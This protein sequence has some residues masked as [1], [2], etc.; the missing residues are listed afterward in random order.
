MR[1]RAGQPGAFLRFSLAA[2]MLVTAAATPAAGIPAD[3][4]PG[5][6]SGRVT[7]ETTGAPIAG[8]TIEF[9]RSDHDETDFVGV[10][11]AAGNYIASGWTVGT[12]HARTNNG[13]GY[14]DEL[15]G[16]LPCAFPSA[17]PVWTC[18][19]AASTSIVL[20][21]AP[22]TSIDFVLGRGGRITGMVTDA[23][24]RA[25]LAGV[26]VG[27]DLVRD[28]PPAFGLAQ[29]TTDPAGA[30]LLTGLPSGSFVASTSNDQGYVNEIY[31]GCR[32]HRECQGAPIAVTAGATTSGIDFAL[33]E[34]G[35]V[36]GRVSNAAGESLVGVG[37]GLRRSGGEAAG[38]SNSDASGAW[39][40]DGL[41][42][43]TYF[44]VSQNNDEVIKQ[45]YIDEIFNDL[46]WRPGRD[47]AEGQPIVVRGGAAT[48]GVDFVLEPG[49]EIR[50]VVT[51]AGT[52]A[53]IEARIWIQGDSSGRWTSRT[54]GSGSYVIRGLPSGAYQVRVGTAGYVEELFEDVPCPSVQQQCPG[55]TAVSVSPGS[56][57]TVD[58]A[59]S[60]GGEIAG[61]VTQA[62]SGSPINLHS[63]RIIATDGQPVRET[64]TGPDGSYS[65]K[66]LA[67]GTYYVRTGREEG[68]WY[69]LRP[70]LFLEELFDDQPCLGSC[71]ITNGTPVTVTAGTRATGVDFVLST[72]GRIKGQV[73]DATTGSRL[74]G[75][76]VEVFDVNGNPVASPSSLVP[77]GYSTRPLP[78]G[79]YFARTVGAGPYEDWL[80]GS[81]PCPDGNCTVTDG[82]PITVTAGSAT[83]VDFA[84]RRPTALHTIAPC[85]VLDTRDPDLGGPDPLAA[86]SRRTL[87]MA[88]AACGIPDSAR[89]VAANVTVVQPAATGHL[90][91]FRPD[92]GTPAASTANYSAG[93]ARATNAVIEVSYGQF[94]A[95]VGQPSGTVHVIIDATGYFE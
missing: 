89:A 34:G 71:P 63:V 86:G 32:H 8:V 6:I 46:V 80:Y 19:W 84:L 20:T 64:V 77:D 48:T 18:D 36:A 94:T 73:T 5:P 25:P 2:C 85:R 57:V 27:I 61:V 82:T 39:E 92:A 4:V 87:A 83:Q 68:T 13:S 42:P 28:V 70:G 81:G 74:E 26:R 1:Q 67:S 3:P 7:D 54:D 52:G 31:D 58:F 41:S 62:S 91:L 72:G 21:Q 78:P 69:V 75:I 55:G 56:F 24:T 16:G 40:V 14:L 33:D 66:G 30:Y 60:A 35:R 37:I 53:P 59:L 10:T 47:V 90:R 22:V 17:L 65:A 45:G 76:D 51:D 50:G 95:F 93:L 23:A 49:G 88:T 79:T 15:Y 29:T 12:Y 11:D 44:A 9:K 43:G 38:S